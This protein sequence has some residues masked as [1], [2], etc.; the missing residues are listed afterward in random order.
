MT[1]QKAKAGQYQLDVEDMRK[2]YRRV[3]LM[4]LLCTYVCAHV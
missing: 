4:G 1:S 3:N 2:G